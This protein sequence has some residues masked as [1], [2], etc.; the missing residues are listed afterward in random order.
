MFKF[1]LMLLTVVYANTSF[2]MPTIDIQDHYSV[3]AGDLVTITNNH[4]VTDDYD[5][6]IVSAPKESQKSIEVIENNSIRFLADR[7]G[8]YTFLVKVTNSIGEVSKK[9]FNIAARLPQGNIVYGP[10]DY[11]IKQECVGAS[12]KTKSCNSTFV[13]FDV[14]NPNASHKMII[15]NNSVN[16]AQI[17]LN[18][19][20]ITNSYDFSGEE[21]ILVKNIDV[22]QSN[23]LE[24][25][26]GGRLNDSLT[27]TVVEY[28]S[29]PD[30]N[31]PPTLAVN[32]LTYYG[33]SGASAVVAVSD[34]EN[35][36]VTLEVL[37]QPVN[38]VVTIE[39]NQKIIF[40][41]YSG[42]YIN[43][44]F[45]L[46]ARDNGEP[47]KQTST[48]VDINFSNGNRAPELDYSVDVSHGEIVSGEVVINDN[49][50]QSHQVEVMTAPT[51]GSVSINNE[52]IF[53]YQPN[54]GFVGVD[55]FLV[56]V[57]DDQ[58]PALSNEIQVEI[59]V[60]ENNLPTIFPIEDIIVEQGVS[61][62]RVIE[63]NDLDI[64]QELRFSVK[65]Q[66]LSGSVSIN[67]ITG[68]FTYTPNS[69]FSGDDQFEIELRDNSI[70]NGVATKVISTTVLE[71]DAPVISIRGDRRT[72][73]E[74]TPGQSV[75]FFYRFEDA[76]E[77]Q[78]HDVSVVNELVGGSVLITGSQIVYT[79][80][81][82]FL[83]IETII[84]EVKDNGYPVKSGLVTLE[85]VV[86]NNQPPEPVA[87]F[88]DEVT[89]SNDYTISIDPNDI[90][91]TIDF[92]YEV[93]EGPSFGE[94]NQLTRDN[95]FRYIPRA[96]EYGQER[97]V[98]RVWDN[99]SPS[100]FGDVEI[101]FNAV[102]N[103]EAT[104][105]DATFEFLPFSPKN[106]L[107]RCQD[108]DSRKNCNFEF[109]DTPEY[110]TLEKVSDRYFK[111][112]S[113]VQTPV[114][115]TLRVQYTD[116]G[117]PPVSKIANIT[118][119]TIANTQPVAQ[120]FNTTISSGRAQH[121][122]LRYT[123]VDRDQDHVANII[124]PPSNGSLR[125]SYNDTTFQYTPN[126]GFSGLDTFT[127]EICDNGTPVLCSTNVANIAVTANRPPNV[128]ASDIRLLEGKSST[129]RGVAND[130]DNDS[131]SL[132]LLVNP[133]GGNVRSFRWRWNQISAI[134][135]PNE[136]F[137]GSD[138]I[139]FRVK[140][141]NTR[142]ELFSDLTMNIQVV[143][144]VAPEFS[145]A[146][147]VFVLEGEVVDF[148]GLL[149]DENDEEFNENYNVQVVAK[150]NYGTLELDIEQ[151]FA[152]KR[153]FKYQS[154][155]GFVGT[156]YFTVS[157]SDSNGYA[158]KTSNFTIPIN[159][160]KN[161]VPESTAQPISVIAGDTES[162]QINVADPNI[163]Q[164][165][166]FTIKVQAEKGEAVV[167]EDGFVTYAS[168]VGATGLDSFVITVKDSG[169]V[170]ESF[171]LT[172]PVEIIGNEPPSISISDINTFEGEMNNVPFTLSDPNEGQIVSVEIYEGPSQGT[173]SIWE[174]SLLYRS[175]LVGQ[176]SDSIVL[177][178]TD[179]ANPP[180]ET[181]HTVNIT[182]N[183]N[184]PPS[185][186]ANPSSLSIFQSGV[187]SSELSYSDIDGH[188]VT[189]GIEEIGEG[190][191]SA[192]IT[193]NSLNIELVE[194]Y[195]VDTF[196]DVYA[197]DSLSLPKKSILRI[198]ISIVANTVPVISLEDFSVLENLSYSTNIDIVDPDVGQTHSIS[199]VEGTSLGSLNISDNNLHF[200]SN[201]VIGED[202]ITL[203]V[204][205][206]A[207]PAGVSTKTIN[208]SV[209]E[210]T[211][212][213]AGDYSL[214]F[215]WLDPEKNVDI[216][217]IDPDPNQSHYISVK[218]STGGYAWVSESKLYYTPSYQE[219]GDFEVV[220]EISDNANPPGVSEST[221]NIN[222][223]NHM[224]SISGPSEDSTPWGVAVE[225]IFQ[226]SDL[227]V[228]QE[229]E[230]FI[231]TH[232]TNGHLD[233]DYQTNIATYTPFLDYSGSDSY[234]V[235][236]CESVPSTFCAEQ[237]VQ[238]AV[239]EGNH[240]PSVNADDINLIGSKI[241]T[242]QINVTDYE[243]GQEHT[244]E[245]ISQPDQGVLTVDENGLVTFDGTS[246]GDGYYY[247]S[248]NVTDNG[249]PNRSA[250]AFINI[251]L[252]SNTAPI[253]NDIFTNGVEN[254]SITLDADFDD[255]DIGQTHHLE[256]ISSP[257]NGSVEMSETSFTYTPNLGFT[258]YENITLKVIDSAVPAGEGMFSVEIYVDQ[259]YPPFISTSELSGL[260]NSS[261][262]TVVD[263]SDPN[264]DLQELT[265]SIVEAPVNG[266]ASLDGD[267]LTYIPNLDFVG[268]DF[269]TL[270]VSDNANPS[271]SY[272]KQIIIN[273]EDGDAVPEIG[274]MF[275]E[276]HN[277]SLPFESLL[278]LE[279]LVNAD[280]ISKVEIDF[281]DGSE[282]ITI[283]GPIYDESLEIFNYYFSEDDFTVN[284]DLYDYFGQKY[285]YTI[286]TSTISLEVPVSKPFVST[287]T[288][289]LGESVTLDGS[290]SFSDSND[291]VLQA[292]GIYSD[293][294]DEWIE[295]P[296]VNFT[297]NNSGPV[298]LCHLVLTSKD[299]IN[300]KCIEAYVDMEPENSDFLPIVNIGGNNHFT[301]VGTSATLDFSNT[302]SINSTISSI[303][304]KK[305]N[306]YEP[307]LAGE[308]N[309]VAFDYP[310]VHSVIASIVDENGLR[311]TVDKKVYVGDKDTIDNFDFYV[312]DSGG[313]W[314]NIRMAHSNALYM[315]PSLYWE[316]DNDD[317]DGTDRPI[318]YLPFGQ[319]DVRLEGQDFN[320]NRFEV[321]KTVDTDR[322]P[323][324]GV[325]T[326][327]LN[328]VLPSQEFTVSFSTSSLSRSEYDLVF[329]F[330]N[331]DWKKM[332]GT[333][334]STSYS[335]SSPGYYDVTVY[336]T[337]HA[338]NLTYTYDTNIYVRG[339]NAPSVVFD[340]I[341]SDSVIPYNLLNS[342]SASTDDQSIVQYKWRIEGPEG[343]FYVVD[344][345]NIDVQL[346]NVGWYE[347]L[348][349]VWD[350]EGN[351]NAD[352]YQFYLGESDPLI[353]KQTQKMKQDKIVPF[354]YRSKSSFRKVSKKVNMLNKKVK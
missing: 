339:V 149:F 158:S 316:T 189:V 279:E 201:G 212:P 226:V 282:L 240:A 268:T 61:T 177:K 280:Q 203:E 168:D 9:V 311:K 298:E 336:A 306:Q 350:N 69:D 200:Q 197:L 218:S 277:N 194:G 166:T 230:I 136:G 140:E 134:Y 130:P 86:K 182:I 221:V 122:F 162:T 163:N 75:S 354:R 301:Q 281:G 238:I 79:A 77:N 80:R 89:F 62:F 303:S 123:D 159:V 70:I 74:V 171:D 337:V 47:S 314:M 216:V 34:N 229:H 278:F 115:E 59:T 48:L 347:V 76:N 261:S 174:N 307:G 118:F 266:T 119:V 110:G 15:E 287:N 247:A 43:S 14:L 285:N 222:V 98:I 111:Y 208:I 234:T 327:N 190:V 133:V 342:L 251:L 88:P 333:E 106:F 169:V 112:T 341:S 135:T 145:I 310:G 82:D 71:N 31:T 215:N 352:Y 283:N 199:I 37:S 300:E 317:D 188:N 154:S 1:L 24:V 198:P 107:L 180:L 263:Y 187:G 271:L 26:L 244:F 40:R 78:V 192:I 193:D 93:I 167:N 16:Y 102:E 315:T 326:S 21:S 262:S 276:Y 60:L 332:V 259:N 246:A 181:F 55:T 30:S 72:L 267:N 142:D 250:T 124:T 257:S 139:V 5:W 157:V 254:T 256:V 195:V 156:D 225:H 35:H 245:V 172:I 321:V 109:L 151:S 39:N 235:S 324:V 323:F 231:D 137:V 211:P 345:P 179:D 318:F 141:S 186:L 96:G 25:L 205:D 243:F 128:F 249:T 209:Y 223:Q 178:V 27:I 329:D 63:S 202:T 313:S 73:K 28:S 131:L 126:L 153:K 2:A 296:I 8:Q 335:F 305:K 288:F 242:T 237:I 20:Q 260:K 170:S 45:V 12:S 146:N 340:S 328:E 129:I 322:A 236:V 291:I 144:N 164:S 7:V 52:G 38:G 64:N 120:E 11:L 206:N 210:N 183:E 104:M 302:Y 253:A 255:P 4:D 191:K 67:Q 97:I 85:V 220:L 353:G 53:A 248:I 348:G 289:N 22:L 56:K 228:N 319:N 294:V 297:F 94:L 273:V 161:S 275:L 58:E 258:G 29:I 274:F 90:D 155:I 100:M 68:A 57:T 325:I 84:V 330:G 233:L 101:L 270:S 185:V 10:N 143:E 309:N 116:A 227:D 334:S 351:V 65:E 308:L 103:V 265:L 127:F 272:Q 338:T 49:V 160:I 36:E 138:N 19:S 343:E 99:G 284:I 113:N 42:V 299:V 148:E 293:F 6:T 184:H 331:G 95:R 173:S 121:L 252:Q 152:E 304:L 81:E 50:G 292:W 23:N 320:N 87:H 196:V 18:G 269:V 312:L 3:V 217:V 17:S 241:G 295:Q 13:D 32:D 91:S 46:G 108:P 204:R 132:S 349:F 66:P 44:S 176:T 344:G 286:D 290:G 33:D 214:S 224:P 219:V 213:T 346:L 264:G 207:L 232:P 114:Q 83:G 150:P 54:G 117:Y 105:A 239:T 51:N 165:H 175:N 125:R 92:R 41:P 147:E